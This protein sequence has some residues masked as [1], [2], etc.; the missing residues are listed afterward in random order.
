MTTGK[1]QLCDKIKD[2]CDSHSIPDSALKYLFRR[3]S[4]KAIS[5]IGDDETAI[6][7]TQESWDV[8][9]LCKSCEE[10]LNESY[11]LYGLLVLRG[12]A[13]EVKKTSYGV[14]FT[15]IDK[16]RFRMFI[17]STIWR[18]SISPHKCYGNIELPNELEEELKNGIVTQR[19]AKKSLFHV[20]LYRMTDSSGVQGFSN[21]ELR[22]LVCAPFARQ[23]PNLFSMCFV[24]LGFFVEV[25]VGKMPKKFRSKPGILNGSSG[26]FMA[27]HIELLDI[28]ELVNVLGKCLEKH[29]QGNT[30]IT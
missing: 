20:A 15:G 7:Y 6:Q 19:Q 10:N 13:C 30:K 22:G 14:T 25:F 4:G 26:I 16:N 17:L 27:P 11:D 5:L 1:C 12:N 23:F 3:S 29:E 9:L 2:L 24:M 8:P 18:I 28:P 21:E